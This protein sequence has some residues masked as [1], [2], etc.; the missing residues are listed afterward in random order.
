MDAQ[1]M[2]LTPLSWEPAA[3]VKMMRSRRRLPGVLVKSM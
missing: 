1:L 2:M 3:T